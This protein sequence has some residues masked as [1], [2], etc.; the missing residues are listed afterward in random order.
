MQDEQWAGA[1]VLEVPANGK[2]DYVVTYTPTA[3]T[4]EDAPHRGSGPVIKKA[5]P[6][7]SAATSRGPARSL[8]YGSPPRGTSTTRRRSATR[9]AKT[10]NDPLAD[11][12]DILEGWVK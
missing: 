8:G 10:W 3:M 4:P 7:R 9:A 6:T 12:R 1:E 2:A 5:S 11:V